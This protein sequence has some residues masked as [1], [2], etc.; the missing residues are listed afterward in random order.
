MGKAL[1]CQVSE[2]YNNA[3]LFLVHALC[4]SWVCFSSASMYLHFRTHTQNSL[5]WDT[6]GLVLREKK[7][8]HHVMI[9]KTLLKT[10]HITFSH[11]SMADK[12]HDQG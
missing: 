1:S 7:K 9:S 10:I 5:S 12:S 2:L 3:H 6:A 4:P 8:W 11:I